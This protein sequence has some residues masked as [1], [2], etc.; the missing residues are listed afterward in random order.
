VGEEKRSQG[1]MDRKKWKA[2]L[3]RGLQEKES[4]ICMKSRQNLKIVGLLRVH[5]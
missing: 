3:R 4:I 2:S 5:G 1:R